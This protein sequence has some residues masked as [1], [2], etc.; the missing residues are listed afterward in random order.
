MENW[1][2]LK[3]CQLFSSKDPFSTPIVRVLWDYSSALPDELD[4]STGDVISVTDAPKDGWWSGETV[5]EAKRVEGRHL[6]PSNLV[7]LP[8][9]LSLPSEEA[10]PGVSEEHASRLAENG[11]FILFYGLFRFTLVHILCSSLTYIVLLSSNGHI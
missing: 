6:F 10:E 1:S 8:Q 4:L 3:V 2:F 11:E 5:D 9:G 7:E